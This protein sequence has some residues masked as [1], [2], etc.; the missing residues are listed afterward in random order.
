MQASQPGG[1]RPQIKGIR[2]SARNGQEKESVAQ[3]VKSVQAGSGDTASGFG[4]SA[5][6]ET[7]LRIASQLNRIDCRSAEFY[8]SARLKI[9]YRNN[10]GEPG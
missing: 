5:E 9:V 3:L 6:L 1:Q 2:D 8:D 10:Q 7:K 4:Q